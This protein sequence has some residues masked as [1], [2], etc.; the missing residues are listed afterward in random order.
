MHF[1]RENQGENGYIGVKILVFPPVFLA[2]SLL[3]LP[4][5]V[6]APDLTYRYFFIHS[7]EIHGLF[8]TDL[9]GILQTFHNR[10]GGRYS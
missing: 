5:S 2:N 8:R 7:L 6:S 10:M 9:I 3:I 4:A 1:T